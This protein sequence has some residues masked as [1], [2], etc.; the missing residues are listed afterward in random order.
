M[1]LI[2]SALRKLQQQRAR[3]AAAPS[4]AQPPARRP[5]ADAAAPPPG[6]V[7]RINRDA[8]RAAGLFPPA[9]QEREI[10][11]QFRQ[12]K[13]PLIAS[14]TGRASTPLEGG[15]LIMIASAT[16]AEGK[17]F[18]AVNLALS[19]A[20][21]RDIRVLLV[22]A[23]VA[24]PQISRLLGLGAE[25]GLLD[26]LR[27]PTLDIESLILPCDVPGLSFL[28][29]GHHSDH[30]TELLASD[31]MREIARQIGEYDP[32]RI[33]LFDSPPLLHTTQG[34]ALAQALG[35]VVLVVRAAVTPQD[36]VAHT[37][38]RLGEGKRISVVL[39]QAVGGLRDG[40]PLYG[41][42]EV[43]ASEPHT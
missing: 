26:A 7:T 42:P 30:T 20:F 12:I 13:R 6:K 21:E 17:T 1:S 14:A 23:D 24:K 33:A 36:A 28:P 32:Q 16:P 35:Q 22:D 25:P 5:Q 9:R 43:T 4:R 2:E 11:E 19:M 8:L 38:E 39:N 29:A 3:P 15:N 34:Q 18:T 40:Y 31:R 41:Q 27:D 37:I 10:A